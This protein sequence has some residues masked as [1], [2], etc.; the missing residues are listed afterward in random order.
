MLS[1]SQLVD[2]R[3]VS[4]FWLLRIVWPEHLRVYLCGRVVIFC[5]GILRSRTAVLCDKL[6]FNFLRNCSVGFQSVC[7]AWPWPPAVCE[8]SRSSVCPW[9]HTCRCF[10]FFI[11]AIPADVTWC[12]I[13]VLICIS[14][15]TSD[16]EHFCQ[17]LVAFCI[18]S[19]VKCLFRY[20]VLFFFDFF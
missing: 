7:S 19:L 4:A 11:R 20:L 12:L 2:V 14:V 1:C 10:F 3:S 5:G 8:G 16:V 13:W 17:F 9:T 6:M 15:T 18:S